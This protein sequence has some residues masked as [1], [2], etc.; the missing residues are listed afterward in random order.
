MLNLELNMNVG[1]EFSNQ[2]HI[3]LARGTTKRQHSTNL[4]IKSDALVLDYCSVE[5]LCDY[6]NENRQHEFNI[7]FMDSRDC[8]VDY[9]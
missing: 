5:L 3:K 7:T 9:I 4:F 2:L 1:Q 6:S 8:F